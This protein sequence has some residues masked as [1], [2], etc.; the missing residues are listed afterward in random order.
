MNLETNSAHS[1]TEGSEVSVEQ[2]SQQPI[3]NQVEP[4]KSMEQILEDN[5]KE[6]EEFKNNEDNKK[7]AVVLLKDFYSIMGDKWFTLRRAAA[8]TN[9]TEMLTFQKLKLLE[10]FGYCVLKK[11][12]V[13]DDKQRGQ[14]TF[15]LIFDKSDEL[16]ALNDV[17]KQVTIEL[18]NLNLK[19]KILVEQIEE[20]EKGKTL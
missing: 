16:K 14:I 13:S 10:M 17:I 7:A 11:G 12:D 6:L 2:G 9:M 20:I 4:P 8:K 19:R 18:E 5:K 3:V 15:K 1:F